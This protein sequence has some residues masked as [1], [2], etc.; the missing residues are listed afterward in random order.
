MP[1]LRNIGGVPVELLFVSGSL[2]RVSA[3]RALL[4]VAARCVD[5][6]AHVVAFDGIAAIPHFDPDIEHDELPAVD[7]WKDA[8]RSA[9]GVLIA[10]PEYAHSLPG[11]L[12]NALDWLVGTGELYDKPV[13]LM[14]AGTGGGRLAL[15]ALA[16]TLHA[17]GARVVD[18]LSVAGV[19]PKLDERGE[20]AD[21]GTIAGTCT[22]VGALLDTAR[23]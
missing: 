22:L 12:K 8:V 10:T 7:A 21:A 1:G 13:A 14:S 18:R 20:I 19:R 16:Q 5:G 23:G 4:R 2:Q 11:S 9:H 15:D 17:Q 3:N 6:R